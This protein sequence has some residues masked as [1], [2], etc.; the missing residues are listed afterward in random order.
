MHK[1]REWDPV[2]KTTITSFGLG[3]N[4][5]LDPELMIDNTLSG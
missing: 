4:L 2:S 1:S 5:E 3:L